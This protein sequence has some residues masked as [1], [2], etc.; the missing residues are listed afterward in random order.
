MHEESMEH[1]LLLHLDNDDN[2]IAHLAVLEGNSS[3]FKVRTYMY[4]AHPY[5]YIYITC[6]VQAKKSSHY[7]A[8]VRSDRSCKYG[9]ST[10]S[11]RSATVRYGGVVI[12]VRRTLLFT[13]LY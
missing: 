6:T 12:L 11:L 2:T 1:L 13:T 9:L 10:V 7:A 3:V 8:V 4:N 5:V